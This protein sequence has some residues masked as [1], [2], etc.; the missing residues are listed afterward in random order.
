MCSSPQTPLTR[1]L[2]EVPLLPSDSNPVGSTSGESA[3]VPSPSPS[4]PKVH[5][6]SQARTGE[7]FASPATRIIFPF[8]GSSSFPYGIQQQAASES[9]F[10]PVFS[11]RVNNKRQRGHASEKLKVLAPDPQRHDA[12]SEWNVFPSKQVVRHQSCPARGRGQEKTTPGGKGKE[13]EQ[14]A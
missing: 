1:T 8:V 9:S 4:L 6:N 7:P 12:G 14:A 10:G 3:C 2:P 13:V 11:P 5:A